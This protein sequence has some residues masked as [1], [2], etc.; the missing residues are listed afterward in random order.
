MSLSG[1]GRDYQPVTPD[2]GT[3]LPQT[4]LALYVETG[5]AVRFVSVRGETRTV[6]VP[7]FGWVLCGVDQVM[8]TGTTA[9]GIHAVTL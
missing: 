5:G 7:D 1:P 3:T 4:A 2:D 9:A 6:A 8:A